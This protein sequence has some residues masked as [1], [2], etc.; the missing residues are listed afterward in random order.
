MRN[1]LGVSLAPDVS[2]ARLDERIIAW[3]RDNLGA[4]L[5]DGRETDMEVRVG[6]ELRR[7]RAN[8]RGQRVCHTRLRAFERAFERA[9]PTSPYK[10]GFGRAALRNDSR[11]H[12][13][14]AYKVNRVRLKD[15]RVFPG[16]V[17][18]CHDDVARI[19]EAVLEAGGGY[20]EI[21]IAGEATAFSPTHAWWFEGDRRYVKELCNMLAQVLVLPP[22]P[23]IDA[24]LAG[25]FYKDP[26][27]DLPPD[28]WPNTAFGELVNRAKY[29][30][31]SAAFDDLT[32]LLVRMVELHPMMD[33]DVVLIPPA[34][35]TGFS[36]KI[37]PAVA[38]RLDV[39]TISAAP[40]DWDAEPAKQGGVGGRTY[41]IDA[42]LFGQHVL[43]VDDVW[44]SGRTAQGLAVAARSQ[45]AAAVCAVVGA[46]TM[47]K[48]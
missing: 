37:A 8:P 6:T 27:D 5:A 32:R 31:D 9:M 23:G 14:E 36:E 16:V 19:V 40:Q 13:L 48:H 15:G 1:R 21:R 47:R 18:K 45:G 43:I 10:Q 7:Y 17:L 44:K 38:G 30:G 41:T 20:G 2:S 4:R 25:D 11:G 22:G 29:W 3:N 33:P 46:R 26:D 24:A 39:P 12:K 35:D 28:H 34:S 42:A